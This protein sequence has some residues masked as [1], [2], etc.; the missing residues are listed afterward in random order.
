MGFMQFGIRLTRLSKEEQQ[1]LASPL[2]DRAVFST[3]AMNTT[4][5]NKDNNT[6]ETMAGL[7]CE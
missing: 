7:N 2:F 4:N 6:K 3:S 5:E 1:F